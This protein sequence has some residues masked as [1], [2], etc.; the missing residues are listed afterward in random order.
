MKNSKS[1]SHKL[2]KLYLAL[3]RKYQKPKKIV[4][5]EP[6]E[7]IVYAIISEKT[8]EAEAQAAIKRFDEKFVNLNDLRV[9]LT[10]EVVEALGPDMPDARNTAS[11]LTRVLYYV[12]NHYHMVSLAVLK[13][14]GKRPARQT[15]EKIEGINTFV[16]DYCMLTAL[17]GHAIPLTAKMIEYLK[18]N[19]IVDSGADEQEI[20]GFLTKQISSDNACEFYYLLRCESESQKPRIKEKSAGKPRTKAKTEARKKTKKSN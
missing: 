2:R 16:V 5:D 3:K 17:Q 9:S 13:K 11:V 10:E 12:F 1:Y 6:V 19:A 15:L 7:A 14:I 18:N 20:E 8:T 4:Y